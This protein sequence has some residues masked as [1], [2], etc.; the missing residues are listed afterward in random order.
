MKLF[1]HI[2][3]YSYFMCNAYMV[4]YLDAGEAKYGNKVVSRPIIA[5][6]GLLIY[7]IDATIRKIKRWWLASIWIELYDVYCTHTWDNPTADEIEDIDEIVGNILE[8]KRRTIRH[9]IILKV[10]NT[11]K[12]RY[13]TNN[14]HE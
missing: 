3:I 6:F 5:F 1:S 10:A 14:K 8:S 9:R 7:I 13:I 11:V 4:G 12:Q 2:L